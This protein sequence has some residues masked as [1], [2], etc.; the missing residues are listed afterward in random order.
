MLCILVQSLARV[1]LRGPLVYRSS[2]NARRTLKT[3]AAKK[4]KNHKIHCKYIKSTIEMQWILVDFGGF[5]EFR[6]LDMSLL[7]LLPTV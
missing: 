6:H 1:L 5:R 2:L 4:Y 7:G 3:T